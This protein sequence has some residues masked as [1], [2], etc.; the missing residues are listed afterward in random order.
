M[1]KNIQDCIKNFTKELHERKR[2]GRAT[3]YMRF[4]KKQ[5]NKHFLNSE[6]LSSLIRKFKRSLLSFVSFIFNKI[7]EKVEL[8]TN[9][10][11]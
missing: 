5:W 1:E 9:L 10:V 3:G 11:L 7:Y 4:K 6:W 8:D 2:Q